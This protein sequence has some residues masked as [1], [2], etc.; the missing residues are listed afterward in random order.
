VSSLDGVVKRL[1]SQKAPREMT[2]GE[3]NKALDRVDAARCKNVDRFIEAG[4]GYETSSQIAKLDDPLAR[5]ANA[6]SRERGE[7]RN[8]IELRYGPGAPSR[9]PKGRFFGP[10]K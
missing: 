4:R 3:L 10:R 1:K 2:A 8:E 9:L 5:E 6:L 7:L